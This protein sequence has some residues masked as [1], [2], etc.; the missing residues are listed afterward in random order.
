MPF[1]FTAI[2]VHR[3]LDTDREAK[4]LAKL[5][6]TEKELSAKASHLDQIDP[7]QDPTRFQ[8]IYYLFST[9][10]DTYIRERQNLLNQLD[11]QYTDKSK[12]EPGPILKQMLQ[13]ARDQSNNDFL[14]NLNRLKR[15]VSPNQT[16]PETTNT[17]NNDTI[18]SSN[19]TTPTVPNPNPEASKELGAT[20]KQTIT[21]RVKSILSP[22][23]KTTGSINKEPS[24]PTPSSIP[25]PK[26]VHFSPN[27]TKG[28]SST[29]PL[30]ST[31][32]NTQSQDQASSNINTNTTQQPYNPLFQTPT[33]PNP[34]ANQ[35]PYVP[36][37]QMPINPN[38]TMPQQPHV[39]QPHNHP[40]G[41][42]SKKNI[43]L[44]FQ[45]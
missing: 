41:K 43:E 35:Q 19:N 24:K 8:E 38:P 42:V 17:S 29:T 30:P 5:Q 13:T 11:K 23:S 37:P 16:P 27:V 14:H 6:N 44:Y 9:L 18:T 20:P 31:P 25:S 1:N 2:S 40:Y 34:T 10:Y 12:D 7:I 45:N 39:P 22:S 21:S 36:Q 28:L 33:N 15:V 4:Y 26:N 32:L 3:H